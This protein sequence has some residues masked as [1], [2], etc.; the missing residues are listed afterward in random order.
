MVD[1]ADLAEVFDRVL[2]DNHVGLACITS[3]VAAINAALQGSTLDALDRG[4]A[5]NRLFFGAVDAVAVRGG[6]ADVGYG[7]A[8]DDALWL[9]TRLLVPNEQPAASRYV[10]P[11]APRPVATGAPC[12]GTTPSVG[13]GVAD[14][15]ADDRLVPAPPDASRD[16]RALGPPTVAGGEGRSGGKAPDDAASPRNPLPLIALGIAVLAALAAG[17]ARNHRRRTP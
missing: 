6:S 16:D 14:G 12:E 10:P 15:P 4:L 7:P 8:T 13:A 3:D 2:E 1:G 17:P 9:R 11:R 5:I